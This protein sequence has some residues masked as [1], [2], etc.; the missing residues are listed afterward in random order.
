M[1]FFNGRIIL[2][3]LGFISFA[4]RFPSTFLAMSVFLCDLEVLFLILKAGLEVNI[5]VLLG[6]L[7][8]YIYSIKF[9]LE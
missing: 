2:K 6:L 4:I 1:F 5:L 7:G 3:Q 8:Y 9:L